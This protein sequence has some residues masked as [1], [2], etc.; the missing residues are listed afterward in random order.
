MP[1]H[2]SAAHERNDET[3]ELGHLGDEV[4]PLEGEVAPLEGEV[5][6]LE[7]EVA[8]LEGEVAPLEGESLPPQLSKTLELLGPRP[9][10]KVRPVIRGLCAWREM[11]SEELGQILSRFHKTLYRDHLKPLISEGKLRL[12]YPEMPNHPSQAYLTTPAGKASLKDSDS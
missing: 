4:A 8:P 5:A 1:F 11:S 2:F 6:P 9:G 7:G 10:M 12:K 3:L